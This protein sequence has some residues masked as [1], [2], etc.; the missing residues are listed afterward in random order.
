MFRLSSCCIPWPLAISLPLLVTFTVSFHYFSV[1]SFVAAYL[2][3]YVLFFPFR[4]VFAVFCVACCS[5]LTYLYKA[6][7]RPQFG[8]WSQANF[9]LLYSPDTNWQGSLAQRAR[10]SFKLSLEVEKV[11]HIVFPG[12]LVVLQR[13]L[14]MTWEPFSIPIWS[15]TT[16]F[17]AKKKWGFC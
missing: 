1:C 17:W 9:I 6:L 7:L 4:H 14:G 8:M 5:S 13:Q 10:R 2:A 15:M 16:M 12:A 3:V 11:F